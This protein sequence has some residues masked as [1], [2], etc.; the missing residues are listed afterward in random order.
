LLKTSAEHV[1]SFDPDP[2]A[3]ACLQRN[4]ESNGLQGS[5]KLSLSKTYVGSSNGPGRIS[6]DTL[7]SSLVAPCF[8]KVDIDGGE[9]DLLRAASS[10][11]LHMNQ[12]RWIVETHS[13]ALEQECNGILLSH[14]YVTRI[15]PNAW[16]RAIIPEQRPGEQNRWLIATNDGTL[17]N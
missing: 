6:A 12:L 11:L 8:L 9:G 2:R 13:A 4:L 15:V 1:F 5:P 14:G 17:V 7:A 16:W 10:R 3:V